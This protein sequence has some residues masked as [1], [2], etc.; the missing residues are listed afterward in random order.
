M[1][2]DVLVFSAVIIIGGGLMYAG[3]L[4]GLEVG[5]DRGHKIGFDL[6]KMVGR[7][8]LASKDVLDGF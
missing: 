2:L 3:Y 6:G 8:Q 1:N 4:M 7:K 5:T